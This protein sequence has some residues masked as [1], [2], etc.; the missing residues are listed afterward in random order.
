MDTGFSTKEKQTVQR[1]R[2]SVEFKKE[3][4]RLLIIDGRSA[5]EVAQQLG[6]TASLLYRWKREHLDEL[7]ATSGPNAGSSPAAMAAEIDRL[8]GQLAK[9]ERINLILKKTVGYFA[10]DD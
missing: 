1:K 9:A 5:P 7:E 3:A 10:K 2:Y 8:R 4:A 6:V